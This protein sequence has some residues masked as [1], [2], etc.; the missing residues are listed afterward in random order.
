MPIPPNPAELLQSNAMG[1]L[2]DALR[3]RFDIVIVD[4]PPLLPVTDAA[5]LAAQADGALLVVRHG[6]TTRDEVHQ[7][8][9]RIAAVGGRLLGAVLNMAPDKGPDA[10]SYGYGYAPDK[11][12]R[13]ASVLDEHEELVKGA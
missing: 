9:E 2:L 4:A 12:R 7:S 10:Y 8:T 5:L 1:E 6:K 13:H 11:G 3:A